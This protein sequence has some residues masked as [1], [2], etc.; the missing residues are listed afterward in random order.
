MSAYMACHKHRVDSIWINNC[1][2]SHILYCVQIFA[3]GTSIFDDC[4]G[5]YDDNITLNVINSEENN[6]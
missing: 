6:L 5:S 1:I 2:D 4:M 3:I